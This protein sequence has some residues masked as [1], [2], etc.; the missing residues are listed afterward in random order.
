MTRN[1]KGGKKYKSGKHDTG[2]AKPFEEA[3]EGEVYARVMKLLGNGIVRVFCNDG[4]ERLARI[5]GSLRKRHREFIDVDDIVIVSF[6]GLGIGFSA[7]KPAKTGDVGNVKLEHVDLV[8]KFDA[9]GVNKLKKS[10]ALSYKLI[11]LPSSKAESGF[12]SAMDID[13]LFTTEETPG[14]SGSS[15]SDSDENENSENVNAKNTI[16][17]VKNDD[18]DIDDI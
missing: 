11:T 10:N 17:H 6:R 16:Q 8:Y 1:T 4:Y 12:S 15:D 7:H 3:A 13:D 9:S 5:R 2:D 18:I 14:E